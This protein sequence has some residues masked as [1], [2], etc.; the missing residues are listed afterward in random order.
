MSMKEIVKLIVSL[1]TCPT[2]ESK[3]N[4]KSLPSPSFPTDSH[5]GLKAKEGYYVW[6]KDCEY[7]LSKHFS[8][9]EFK[10]KCSFD[11]CVEQKISITLIEKLEKIRV[12]VGQPLIITSAFRCA[13]H[14]ESIRKSGQSTVVAKKQSQHELGNAADVLPKDRQDIRG[15]F[16]RIC[17]Q[18]F[19]TIGLSDRFLHL[20]ERPDFRR[21][22]Y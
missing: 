16:L 1:L 2:K 18:H 10:C 8:T 11:S 12:E 9:K 19:Q 6:Q 21:W 4:S 14:Q 20:D 17:A 5:F 13:A 22:E 7:P 3:N 15:S